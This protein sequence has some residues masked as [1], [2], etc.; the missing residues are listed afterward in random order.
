M[1][2]LYANSYTHHVVDHKCSTR[3]AI[4]VFARQF[5]AALDQRED[6]LGPVVIPE[7]RDLYPELP[8][9]HEEER[10]ASCLSPA[11]MYESGE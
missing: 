9:L 11:E 8:A 2:T 3:E 1:S 4:L 5:G 6:A 7:A 10:K